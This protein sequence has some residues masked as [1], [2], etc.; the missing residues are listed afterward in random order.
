MLEER[1]TRS[2]H[3]SIAWRAGRTLSPAATAFVELTTAACAE[4]SEPEERLL[5]ETANTGERA[6]S[7]LF[8]DLRDDDVFLGPRHERPANTLAPLP[9]DPI[10][11]GL[12]EPAGALIAQ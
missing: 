1:G 4:L 12:A 11:S 2:F 6:F 3:V 7:R 5:E 8:E 10:F 9:V